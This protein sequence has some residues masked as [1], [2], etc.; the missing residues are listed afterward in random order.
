MLADNTHSTHL[1]SPSAC[2]L[3]FFE[4]NFHNLSLLSVVLNKEAIQQSSS[5]CFEENVWL[6]F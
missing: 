3:V 1:S 5:F 4:L 2:L 6:F